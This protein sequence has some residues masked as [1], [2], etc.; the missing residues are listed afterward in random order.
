MGIATASSWSIF[1]QE[2]LYPIL[3]REVVGE[4]WKAW[5]MNNE[6]RGNR[7]REREDVEEERG[8]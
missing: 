4:G 3:I 2:E 7:T 1:R 6:R 8:D 5:R